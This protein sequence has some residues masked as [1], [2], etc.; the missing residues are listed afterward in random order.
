M[1]EQLYKIGK[2]SQLTGLSVERLRMWE[3]R[4]GISPVKKVNRIRFY[5]EEQLRKLELMKKLIDQGYSISE[6]KDSSNDELSRLIN[7]QPI[8]ATDRTSEMSIVLVGDLW[9]F[10]NLTETVAAKVVV[11]LMTVQELARWNDQDVDTACD[12]CVLIVSSLDVE[13]LVPVQ[14]QLDVPLVVVYRYA[15]KT[16]R[17]NAQQAGLDALR[18][19]DTSWSEALERVRSRVRKQHTMDDSCLV[20]TDEELAHISRCQTEKQVEPQ[21][22]VEIVRL[23]RALLEHA[24]RRI[25]NA[26]DVELVEM[27]RSSE[28]TLEKALSKIVETNKLI[29]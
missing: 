23:Q 15:S 16:D 22:L 11:R 18:F 8:D 7:T 3:Q 28:I 26:Q 5:E 13:N 27:I 24:Q 14:S 9:H 12:A 2:V 10:E 21:D 1:T 6:L 19:K 20:F 4:H 25:E 17:E 29:D